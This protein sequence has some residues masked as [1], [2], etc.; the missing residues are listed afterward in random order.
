MNPTTLAIFFGMLTGLGV[1]IA[2]AGTVTA[3]PDLS[4]ALSNLQPRNLGIRRPSRTGVASTTGRVDTIGQ[5]AR[6][7]T[8][9]WEV[10]RAPERD[11][12]LLQIPVTE[13]YGKKAIGALIGFASATLLPMITG[14][15]FVLPFGLGLIFAA[16]GWFAPDF[17]VRNTATQ[18]RED[19]AYA[20]VSYLRLVA[21]S[22]GAGAGLTGSL[23]SAARTSDS[24]M[25]TRI[26]DELRLANYAGIPAWDALESLAE[27]IEVPELREVADIIRLANSSG[28]AVADN[29]MARAA[30]LR[31]R[32]LTKE[33]TA[34]N[35]A[36][37]SMSIPQS[38]LAAIFVIALIIPPFVQLSAV[39]P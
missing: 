37:T 9:R 21:I 1:A 27:S 31:D 8:Y 20:S 30:S 16:V 10:L 33:K 29:L 5:W 13:H 38:A 24:W 35:A 15:G 11:L 12:N 2:L 7:K 32:L 36:T 34:A 23:E 18:R 6:R 25:F 28:A 26:R 39:G 14:L 19:F 4:S 17:T 22:R 3:R